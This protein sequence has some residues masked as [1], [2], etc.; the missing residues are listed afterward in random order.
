M[1]VA[2]G[3][4]ARV[5]APVPV[6][7]VGGSQLNVESASGAVLVVG[8]VAP[9]QLKHP[10]M[11]LSELEVLNGVYPA[12][13]VNPHCKTVVLLA[14]SITVVHE[15]SLSSPKVGALEVNEALTLQATQE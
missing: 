2:P 12:T 5:I 11:V 7:P 8:L 1:A 10:T 14:L 6:K 4:S 9:A 3:L 13:Q 15:T